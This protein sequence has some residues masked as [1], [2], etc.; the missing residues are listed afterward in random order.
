VIYQQFSI[1]NL[2]IKLHLD[3]KREFIGKN[4]HKIDVILY[5]KGYVQNITKTIDM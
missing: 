3:K 5:I 4:R 1:T 2:N